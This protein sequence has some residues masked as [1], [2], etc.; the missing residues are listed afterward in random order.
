MRIGIGLDLG[1]VAEVVG[2]ELDAAG[3]GPGFG[4]LRQDVLFLLCVTLDRFDQV[5]NEVGAALVFRLDLA[6]F[7][8]DVLL[9]RG[10]AV[11]PAPGQRKRSQRRSPPD[12]MRQR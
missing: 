10:N 7:G 9:G 1:R 8:V 6:P 12:G 5:G 4:D 2:V 11:E 3:L